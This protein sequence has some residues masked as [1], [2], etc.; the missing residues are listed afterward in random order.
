[1]FSALTVTLPVFLPLAVGVVSGDAISG[2][3]GQGTLRYL[4]V[5]RRPQPAPRRQGRAV[6]VFCLVASF[7]VAVS[8]FVVGLVL[9]PI[10]RVTLL[11]GESISFARRW[12]RR[13]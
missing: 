8:A 3:A 7:T 4:L 6:A 5:A 10:G 9:F 11:S 13:C 1:V 12:P 2:E